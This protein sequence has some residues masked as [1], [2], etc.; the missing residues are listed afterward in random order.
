MKKVSKVILLIIFCHLI[1]GYK[2]TDGE[3][4]YKFDK[5]WPILPQPWYFNSPS[6]IAIDNNGNVYVVD[7][8]NHRI[9]K[10]TSD[11][12]FVLKWGSN[13]TGDGQFSSPYGIAVDSSNY[14]YV[15]DSGNHRIQKFTSD[16]N[17]V[18]KW[19]SNGTGDGQF[20]S[21]YGIAVDSSN[22]IYVVD[23]WN[24]RIQKFTSDGTFVLKL[25]SNGTNNGQ[26]N[27]PEGIAVDSSNYVYVV[28]NWNHR[29]QKFTSDGT[30]VLKFGNLGSEKGEFNFPCDLTV[31]INGNIY[32]VDT[33]NNRIQKF[34]PIT[35]NTTPPSDDNK[36][37]A[38]L[39]TGIYPNYIELSK[40]EKAKIVIGESDNVEIR[41]YNIVG[42]LIKSYA[43]RYYNAGDYVEWDGTIRDT[44]IKAGAGIY[45]V[46][47]K[48]DK[49]NIIK[50]LI[51]TK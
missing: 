8:G 22:Y 7:T 15:A 27:Y 26:F 36:S 40:N 18:L 50:K 34:I 4:T 47:I 21:P 14:V 17:F 19:G 13:G 31:D 42:S 49:I 37:N 11:G 46:V 6:D 16:G 2:Y 44:N 25:G 43:K 9:Q 23:N 51:L 32:V 38:S 5:L 41:I 29:I 3:V 45:I 35:N 48:G 10:F 39:Q 28:E 24:H 1:I 20:S 30:F 12:N 33:G